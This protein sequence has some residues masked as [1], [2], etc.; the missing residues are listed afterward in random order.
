MPTEKTSTS[1]SRSHGRVRC[2]SIHPAQMST[3]GLP[4]TLD[5][6]RG[7]ELAALAEVVCERVAHRREAL[8]AAAEDLR[9]V[10]HGAIVVAASPR[11]GSRPRQMV[12]C[13]RFRRR[14]DARQMHRASL[15]SRL[16]G[17]A[18]AA[19]CTM[20]LAVLATPAAWGATTVGQVAPG[21]VTNTCGGATTFIQNATAAA[22]PS[23]VIPAGGGV[24]TSW[25]TMANSTADRKMA[26]K[27]VRRQSATNFLVIGGDAENADGQRVQHLQGP[28]PVLEGDILAAY[29]STAGTSCEYPAAVG[30]NTRYE[31]GSH[32]EPP[33]GTTLAT[34]VQDGNF[35]V[36]I[37]AVLEPDADGDGFGDESQDLCPTNATTQLTCPVPR[38]R[39]K[40]PER[41]RFPDGSGQSAL[42]A[43]IRD[44]HHRRDLGVR[45]RQCDRLR[46][47]AQ[48]SRGRRDRCPWIGYRRP[49][50]C[51]A[52]ATALHQDRQAAAAKGPPSPH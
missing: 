33:V 32:P 29:Y 31:S 36:N 19:L 38:A 1:V 10:G 24:I 51:R 42:G 6:D 22:S 41:Q 11:R 26:L 45:K 4:S 25:N 27:V 50:G 39:H 13:I 40:R 47:V 44:H 12:D 48:E 14:Y 23:Y 30:D 35:R 43:E 28:V 21:G 15:P 8:V 37:A 9:H 34:N 2:R 18:T 3:T 16:T 17:F 46:Q 7:A 20:A 49:A 52:G 5:R